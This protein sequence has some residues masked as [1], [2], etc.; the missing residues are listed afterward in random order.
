MMVVMDLWPI[1][2]VAHATGSFVSS[3]C[4]SMRLVDNR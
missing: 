1:V 4:C 2:E 3:G